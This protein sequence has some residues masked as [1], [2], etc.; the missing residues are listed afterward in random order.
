[1]L[2]R[3]I[4]RSL[5]MS[6]CITSLWG[7]GWNWKLLAVFS[8]M[9]FREYSDIVA[10]DHSRILD[11]S[12][13]SLCIDL[14]SRLSRVIPK[15][16]AALMYSLGNFMSQIYT[17]V[18]FSSFALFLLWRKWTVVL[19]DYPIQNTSSI[20]YF[21]SSVFLFPD[22]TEPYRSVSISVTVELE[23]F[24]RKWTTGNWTDF[25][26]QKWIL[27]SALAQQ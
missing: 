24:Y 7:K 5:S 12:T 3:V 22:I 1:M 6:P 27:S 26:K 14:F 10:V 4:Y 18:F 19:F 20:L 16:A 21:S 17:D 25:T 13:A 15:S 2:E 8:L 9:D 23:G 11:I